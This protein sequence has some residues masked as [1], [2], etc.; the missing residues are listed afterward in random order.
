MD[1]LN[2]SQNGLETSSRWTT[3]FRHCYQRRYRPDLLD[4]AFR[5]LAQEERIEGVNLAKIIL[6]SA[7]QIPDG[8]DP[9]LPQYLE[10]MLNLALVDTCDV[11]VALLLLSQYRLKPRNHVDFHNDWIN[12][13]AVTQ[14]SVLALL[15][16]SFADGTKVKSFQASRRSCRALVYWLKACNTYDTMSQIHTEGGLQAPEPGLVLVFQALGTF[17][18]MLLSNASVKTHLSS[19]WVEGRFPATGQTKISS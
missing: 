18:V 19:R 13:S 6:L 3:L 8:V 10:C 16:G 12:V 5:E 2:A 7:V 15:A 17:A 14:E 9:L 11:L 4:G 1:S